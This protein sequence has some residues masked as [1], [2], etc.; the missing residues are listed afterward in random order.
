MTED[1]LVVSVLVLGSRVISVLGSAPVLRVPPP[2]DPVLSSWGRGGIVDV[3]SPPVIKP[4]SIG[5]VFRVD[6]LHPPLGPVGCISDEVSVN[7]S[8]MVN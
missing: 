7:W 5:R 6:N 2:Q 3:V 8:T 4:A 1:S